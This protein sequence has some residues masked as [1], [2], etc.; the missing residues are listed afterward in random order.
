[1]IDM[2][3]NDHNPNLVSKGKRA[4]RKNTESGQTL[5]GLLSAI[6]KPMLAI[7]AGVQTIQS[8]ELNSK[9]LLFQKKKHVNEA[10]VF[11]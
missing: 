7:L 5:Q 3:N 1:M 8:I 2:Y 4:A 11:G 6:S 10:A 9:S